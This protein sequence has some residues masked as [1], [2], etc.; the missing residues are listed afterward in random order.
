VHSEWHVGH[1]LRRGR[2]SLGSLLSG[3]ARIVG[4][5]PYYGVVVV[6]STGAV[7][8]VTVVGTDGGT[9]MGATEGGVDVGGGP[10]GAGAGA[11]GPFGRGRPRSGDA[12]GPAVVVGIGT[13]RMA[14][15]AAVTAVGEGRR[16]SSWRWLAPTTSGAA[17]SGALLSSSAS[18]SSTIAAT[19]APA[20]RGR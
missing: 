6:T 12:G 19:A 7:V 5:P 20:T 15:G 11:G 1:V 3:P 2:G 9:T 16:G 10:C 14:G 4:A 13:R 8:T 18:T 17:T